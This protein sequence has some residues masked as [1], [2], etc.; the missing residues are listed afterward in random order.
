MRLVSNWWAVLTRAWSVRLLIVA[1]LLSAAEVVLPI[2]QQIYMLPNR[3]FAILS[4]LFTF[5]ALIARIVA[6]RNTGSKP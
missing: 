4:G 1:A 3:L 2:Y 6:Q 5:G